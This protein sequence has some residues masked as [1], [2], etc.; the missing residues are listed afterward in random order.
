VKT[1][2]I[3]FEQFDKYFD[4][5]AVNF[6]RNFTLIFGSVVFFKLISLTVHLGCLCSSVLFV[7][8]ANFAGSVVRKLSVHLLEKMIVDLVV[9]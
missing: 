6:A 5:F 9:S 3:Y 2:N 1:T 7:A 8:R 4:S